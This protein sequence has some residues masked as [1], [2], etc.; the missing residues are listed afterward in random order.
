MLLADHRSTNWGH[1]LNHSK[2]NGDLSHNRQTNIDKEVSENLPFN[3]L[4]REDA[5]I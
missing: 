2:M 5:K 4:I 3:V 1:H